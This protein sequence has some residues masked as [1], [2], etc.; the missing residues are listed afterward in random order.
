MIPEPNLFLIIKL[1]CED[2]LN[3]HLPMARGNT[4]ERI[5]NGVA[6][7]TRP[8]DV[9]RTDWLIH[10]IDRLL[11]PRSVQEDFNRRRSLT[12]ISAVL[13]EGAP[14][15]DPR[16]HRLKKSATLVL[17][18]A[19]PVLLVY[20]AMATGSSLAPAPTPGLGTGHR[21]FD[22]EKSGQRLH[23][24]RFPPVYDVMEVVVGV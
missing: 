15:V 6:K 13:P 23:L 16:T 24:I 4:R 18:D 11:V 14:V 19:P 17:E 22:G 8:N 12:S 7:V 1:F 9:I 2:E 21:H 20:D 3:N 5:I 10:G